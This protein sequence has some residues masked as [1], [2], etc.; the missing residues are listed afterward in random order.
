MKSFEVKIKEKIPT[1]VV[2]QHAGNQDAVEVKYLLEGLKSKYADRVNIARVDA[3]YNGEY[4]VRY[5]LEEYPTYILYKEGQELMRESG[6][7][8]SAQLEEMIT[9]AL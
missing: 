1:L 6:R 9:T 5:K 8:T 3:S 2:F 7:K 4:K